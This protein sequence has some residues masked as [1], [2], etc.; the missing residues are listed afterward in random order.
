[1]RELLLGE[2]FR[3]NNLEI[4]LYRI[5]LV[6]TMRFR[7]SCRISKLIKGTCGNTYSYD[8]KRDYYFG[9]KYCI[10]R[11]V[12]SLQIICAIPIAICKGGW[13][14]NRK[15][16]NLRTYKICKVCGR[17][18]PKLFCHLKT[19]ATSSSLSQKLRICGLAHQINLRICDSGMSQVL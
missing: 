11:D 17:C 15:S 1:M 14:G 16:A 10:F 19:S 6:A 5:K 3:S 7:L 4:Y 2:R 9:K 8:L 13:S 18:G 12:L